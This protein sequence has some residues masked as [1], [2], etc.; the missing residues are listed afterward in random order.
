MGVVFIFAVGVS[1]YLWVLACYT[2]EL[3]G[4]RNPWSVL[5]V[6]VA[7]A[8]LFSTALISLGTTA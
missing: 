7:V 6:M 2:M 8:L 3:H 5:G 4:F 1:Q